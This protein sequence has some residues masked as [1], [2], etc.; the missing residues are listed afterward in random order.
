MDS[1]S[2]ALRK[3]VHAAQAVMDGIDLIEDL[4]ELL[5][6]YGKNV[7]SKG[8]AV[9]GKVIAQSKL[10]SKKA[11]DAHKE[12]MTK[13]I[14]GLKTVLKKHPNQDLVLKVGRG[15]LQANNRPNKINYKKVAAYTAAAAVLAGLMYMNKGKIASSLSNIA[16]KAKPYLSGFYEKSK[17]A[18]KKLATIPL[19]MYANKPQPMDTTPDP[20]TYDEWDSNQNRFDPNVTSTT[21][22]TSTDPEVRARSSRKTKPQKTP[23]KY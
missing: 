23:W 10:W 12:H 19:E 2:P 7:N 8:T 16:T 5:K 21:T 3:K 1:L 13:L 17:A 6:K 14:H 18:I 15:L 4:P 22:T 11:T 20:P 9:T